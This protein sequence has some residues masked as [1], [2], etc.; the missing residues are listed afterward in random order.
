[1]TGPETHKRRRRGKRRSETDTDDDSDDSM[2]GDDDSSGDDSGSGEASSDTDMPSEDKQGKQDRRKHQSILQSEEGMAWLSNLFEGL[3]PD[4]EDAS[5]DFSASVDGL[6]DEGFGMNKQNTDASPEVQDLEEAEES[7]LQ[8]NLEESGLDVMLAREAAM[9]RKACEQVT[10]KN[11]SSPAVESNILES[12][13]QQV[14]E[15]MIPEEAAEETMLN[16]SSLLGNSD[17]VQ[18][19]DFHSSS[20]PVVHYQA[21][22][23]HWFEECLLSV[24]ALVARKQSLDQKSVGEKGELSLVHGNIHGD[25]PGGNTTFEESIFLGTLER[26]W[27]YWKTRIIG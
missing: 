25:P 24:K 14:A 8:E 16:Q 23:G 12:I 2:G 11:M 5:Q 1:M 19:S 3:E 26:S 13:A 9:I 10:P 4:K 17:D 15:G 27:N 22:F 20:T 6:L 18:P 21:A 7:F